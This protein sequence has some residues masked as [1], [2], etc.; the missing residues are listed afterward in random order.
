MTPD[1]GAKCYRC[2]E[3][4]MPFWTSG[5]IKTTR[6]CQSCG[7]VEELISDSFTSEEKQQILCII[8]KLE[9]GKL[10][11]ILDMEYSEKVFNEMRRILAY[12][13]R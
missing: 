8:D 6:A 2:G 13:R 9:E 12:V 10:S 11:Q 7:A 3:N 4:Q 1:R 5:N